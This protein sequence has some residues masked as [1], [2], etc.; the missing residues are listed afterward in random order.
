MSTV[1]AAVEHHPLAVQQHRHLAEGVLEVVLGSPEGE[2]LAPW[3]PGAHVELLLP[4]GLRR[5]YSLCGDPADRRSY[6]IAVLEEPQGRGGSAELH[7]IARTGAVLQV[8]TPRNDFP[9]VDGPRYLF[10]G[11]GI[12]ITPLLPMIERLTA[13]GVPW[14]LVYGGRSR[15]TMAYL[16]RLGRHGEAVDVWPEDERGRPALKELLTAQEPGTLVYACGPPGLLDAVIAAHA[17][18][19][20]LPPLHFERFAASGPIDTSGGAFEVVLA[21]TGKSLVVPEGTSVLK[22]VRTVLPRLSFSCEE[23]YCG[24]CETTVLEGEVDHRD[25]FLDEDE[26]AAGDTMMICVS[27]CRGPRLVLD[28]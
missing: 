12:G 19:P 13:Q 15:T 4:S 11:G 18:V 26:Q 22:T 9:L 10:L 17:E 3:E 25:D 20:G 1:E 2:D 8:R 24:E 14:T 28:L 7:R 23:G 27:R 21:K 6:T 5:Q 16:D